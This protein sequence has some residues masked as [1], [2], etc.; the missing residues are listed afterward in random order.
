MTILMHHEECTDCGE[1]IV[2][3]GTIYLTNTILKKAEKLPVPIDSSNIFSWPANRVSLTDLYF[4]DKHYFKKLYTDTVNYKDLYK[5]FRLKGR[6]T[7]IGRRKLSNGVVST[8]PSLFFRV[9]HATEVD[10][11][12]FKKIT[13]NPTS[14]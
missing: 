11:G 14:P 1:I 3:S 7:D 9:E 12:Y 6:I 5:V 13:S 8:S 4:E 2:D 10:T